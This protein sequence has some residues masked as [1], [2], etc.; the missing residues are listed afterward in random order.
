MPGTSLDTVNALLKEVYEGQVRSQ[1]PEDRVLM[2]RLQSSSAGVTHTAGGKYV[3][4]PIRIS[5]NHGI[6]YRAENEPLP[7][8]KAVKYAEVHIMLKYGYKRARITGQAMRLA[9]TNVQAFASALDEAVEDMKT[10]VALDENRVAHGDGTGLMASFTATVTGTTHTVDNA[11]LLEEGMQVDVLVRTTGV[12]AAGGADVGIVSVDLDTN[13]VVFS[14][15]ITGLATHGVYRQGSYGR[16]PGGLGA[17]VSAT[18]SLYGVDPATVGVWKSIVTAHNGPLSES[19]IISTIDKKR[20]RGG[21]DT[22]LLLSSLGVRRA[23][24]NLLT[25]QR[26][27]T[28]TKEFVGGFKGLAFNHGNEIPFVE[29]PHGPPGVLYGLNEKNIKIYMDEDW[30]FADDDGNRLKW[31]HDYDSWEMFMRKFWELGTSQRNSH[32][33]ITGIT[34]G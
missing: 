8:A 2:K 29:D 30:H 24:F 17:M 28:D 18:S 12:A 3:D 11:Y 4:F 15:S 32:F 13:V 25:Q 34:E 10:G 26:R 14:A 16:E 21:G 22:T 27:F 6:G 7:A 5:R 33:K 9:K 31:V 19:L 23:Y 20:T 1:L